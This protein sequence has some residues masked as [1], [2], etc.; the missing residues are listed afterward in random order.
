MRII[1]PHPSPAQ[2]DIEKT[3][4]SKTQ[5][6]QNETGNRV[7]SCPV[8]DVAAEMVADQANCAI[9]QGSEKENIQPVNEDI[10][11]EN[12]E[13]CCSERTNAANTSEDIKVQ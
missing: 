8:N 2:K 7:N 13:D 12:V 4:V 10:R 5:T 9:L 11:G 3:T 6:I 1:L